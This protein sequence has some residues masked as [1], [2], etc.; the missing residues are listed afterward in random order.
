MI[1]G[2]HLDTAAAGA[3]IEYLGRL[4]AMGFKCSLCE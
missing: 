3:G 2:W 1:A 4:C